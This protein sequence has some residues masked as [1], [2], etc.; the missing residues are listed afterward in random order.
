MG[1]SMGGALAPRAA[2]FEK[3]IKVCIANPGVLNWGGAILDIIEQMPLLG[4]LLRDNP[5][6]F[7]A[8]VTDL[9]KAGALAGIE[10][11]RSGEWWLKDST[12]KH[13]AS[14]PSDMLNKLREFD[15]T[16]IVNRI[17][18]KVLCMDGEAEE[19]SAGQ[20]RK[21]YDALQ[22][23]KDY[24][25]FTAEDTGLVH[26]QVGAT[27]VAEQRVFDWLAENL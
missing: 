21:L 6:A 25:L 3:R 20:A 15:N 26:C 14:S 12:W 24:M 4:K 8:R 22:C 11:F 27:S 17:T 5:A 1:L 10:I 16:A 7:D 23:P 19:Y 2:A 9:M 18:C 13:G